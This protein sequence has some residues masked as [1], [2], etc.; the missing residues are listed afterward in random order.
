MRVISEMAKGKSLA[1]ILDTEGR[2][3]DYNDFYRWLKKDPQRMELFKEAQELR[4]EFYAG[5]IIQIADGDEIE[6]VHRSR[7]RIETRRWLMGMHNKK[8]Y[9]EIKTIEMNTTISIT[10][11]LAQAQQRLI[12]AE[13]VELVEDDNR[14]T[15]S[16]PNWLEQSGQMDR[17]NDIGSD[18]DDTDRSVFNGNDAESRD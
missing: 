8:R 16:T 17:F 1:Q 7:L 9:G 14:D 2:E 6:D 11:A 18:S 15:Y 10:D 4:T 5:E 13:V 12:E 3:I